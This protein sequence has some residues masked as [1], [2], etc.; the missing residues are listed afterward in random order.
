[1]YTNFQ[2]YA[3]ENTPTWTGRNKRR[4]N[5]KTANVMVN[6]SVEGYRTAVTLYICDLWVEDAF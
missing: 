4:E 1:M 3:G 2:H 6:G 5:N